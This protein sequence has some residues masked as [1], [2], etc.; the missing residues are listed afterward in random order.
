M[1]R[2][3]AN[4]SEL[5]DGCVTLQ[6]DVKKLGEIC[7]AVK[8][9]SAALKNNRVMENY[10]FLSKIEETRKALEAYTGVL[11]ECY[12]SLF[13]AADAYEIAENKVLAA[14]QGTTLE[15]VLK[16]DNRNEPKQKLK[17][18]TAL[19]YD[20]EH[21]GVDIDCGGAFSRILSWP[22]Y[23]IMFA[24]KGLEWDGDEFED[25]FQWSDFVD[26]AAGRDGAKGRVGGTALTCKVKVWAGESKYDNAYIYLQTDSGTA[27]ASGGLYNG[28]EKGEAGGEY[29][30]SAVGG[31][32]G[33]GG[34][35]HGIAQD[36]GITWGLG[37]HGSKIKTEADKD[38]KE[39]DFEGS[40]EAIG[41]LGVYSHTKFID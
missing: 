22:T 27:T 28:N 23:R 32:L 16:E 4:A 7:K 30:Y 19:K 8:G 24:L 14:L 40:V 13:Q 26:G 38:G 25:F 12:N 35:F 36:Q 41:G 5:G 1:G 21:W 33:F 31:R 18:K 37:G 3:S 15:E 34:T 29:G 9:I 20:G 2:L 10:D 39:V 6:A 11:N 17:Y